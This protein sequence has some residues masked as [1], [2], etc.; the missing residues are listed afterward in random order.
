MNK[1]FSITLGGTIFHIDEDA[2]GRLDAYLVS[3][4]KHFAA[5]PDHDELIADIESRMAEK[6]GARLTPGKQ[7][8][9]ATDVE[10]IMREMGQPE[11]FDENED[12]PSTDRETQTDSSPIRKRLYRD[13]DDRIASG[14][15][16]GIAAY[17]DL[18][19]RIVR[20]IFLAIFLI[21]LFSN[22]LLG[23]VIFGLYVFLALTIPEAKTP[24]QKMEMRGERFTVANI[25]DQLKEEAE[26]IHERHSGFFT[27]LETKIGALFSTLWRVIR[28]IIL[29]T[30]NVAR[31]LLGA[32]LILFFGGV[33]AFS[34]F[35]GAVMI[36]NVQ[37]PLIG[38]PWKEVAMG[39]A[40]VVGVASVVASVAIPAIFFTLLG[41][42][43]I[44]KKWKTSGFT[45]ATLAGCWILAVITSGVV[46]IDRLPAIRSTVIQ[47]RQ[48]RKSITET[49]ELEA[50]SRIEASGGR[51]QI[52]VTPSSTSRMIVSGDPERVRRVSA[53]VVGQATGLGDDPVTLHLMEQSSN[54]FC[55][56]CD[57]IPRPLRIEITTPHLASIALR[58][59]VVMSIDGFEEP[60]LEIMIDDA[61]H[62]DINGRFDRISGTLL[63]ASRL[64]IMGTTSMLNLEL[65]DA[66]RLEASELVA[67]QAM[68]RIHDV[69]RATV[70]VTALLHAKLTNASRL[71]YV[72]EPREKRI[73]TEDASRAIQI[74]APRDIIDLQKQNP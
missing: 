17:L 73:V 22:G 39:P 24:S 50:F 43:I 40:Y 2:Y 38:F 69:S 52:I 8:I 59:G 16:S 6:F 11:E 44:R 9:S 68:L 54:E 27:H 10:Q 56:F 31:I 58:A 70:Q 25:A 64:S 41:V 23:L 33:W 35:V 32:F 60:S 5:Y 13:P 65:G 63:S 19:P 71:Q 46:F 7:T 42:A 49:V 36:F 51:Y 3:I 29:V 74:D 55:L 30:F 14:V 53:M 15:L 26:K 28:A 48:S 72:G 57:I 34:L 62:A 47:E 20:G 21:A 67:A 66:S 61:S 45:V 4:K 12:A 37:S 1:T 18:R